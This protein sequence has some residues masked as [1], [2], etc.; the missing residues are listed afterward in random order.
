VLYL[1]RRAEFLLANQNDLK[2]EL[3]RLRVENIRLGNAF[4]AAAPDACMKFHEQ[5]EKGPETK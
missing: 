1:R 5:E 2:S 4:Y 3:D